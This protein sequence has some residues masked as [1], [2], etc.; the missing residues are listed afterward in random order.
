MVKYYKKRLFFK[1][2]EFWFDGKMGFWDLFS[3]K[4]VLH[5]KSDRKLF[6]IKVITHTL[7]LNLEQEKDA[8]FLN[9]SKAN[10]QQ[11]KKA[12]ES[13]VEIKKSTDVKKF[14]NFF[15]DFA[16]KR[17]T[18]TTSTQSIIEKKDYLEI[19]FAS[20]EGDIIAAQ[21]FI[22]DKDENI[23]RHY[24]SANKRF[25][26]TLNKNFAAHANKYLLV[27]NIIRFK[28]EGYK[29]FDFGGYVV[30]T[31]D[32]GL[33]GINNY[34]LQFGGKIVACKDYYSVP[35]WLLKKLGRLLGIAGTV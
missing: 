34:K 35:F 6:G 9:F 14:V 28:E 23:V 3:F 11:I 29:T 30:S 7:E 1:I 12:Q 31:T 26:G 10:R 8:I 4:V 16:L 27:A 20:F 21:S 15:N 32:K 17:G 2:Q 13:G 25:E 5:Y 24:Q 22:V 18:F 19:S 33:L